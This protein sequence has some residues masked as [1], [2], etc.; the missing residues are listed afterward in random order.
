MRQT[1]LNR[2][3]N[4]LLKGEAK[5]QGWK[6]VGGQAYWRISNLFFTLLVVTGAREQSLHYSLRFKWFSP[7]DL[8]W[9]ILGMSSNRFGPISLRANGAFTITGQEL[10]SETL[11]NCEWSR[12]WIQDRIRTIASRAASKSSEVASGVSSIDDYLSFIEREHAA[13]MIR[14]PNAVVNVWKE[15]LLVALEKGDKHT[16]AAI[17][18]TR[19]A[20]KDTGSLVVEGSTFFERAAEYLAR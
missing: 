19:I 4:A 7:D 11:K 16:A 10:L 1:E 15:S 13:L 5:A 9:K 20:A 12:E 6:S 3:V 14:H 8:L 17:A 18:A 2:L